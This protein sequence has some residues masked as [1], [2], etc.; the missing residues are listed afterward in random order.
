MYQSKD[1]DRDDKVTVLGL[2]WQGLKNNR[3]AA[4]NPKQPK[5][6]QQPNL[7]YG[8]QLFLVNKKSGGGILIFS[9]CLYSSGYSKHI[10]GVCPTVTYV[11]IKLNTLKIGLKEVYPLV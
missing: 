11:S 9:T 7:F 8:F 5:K 2:P 6:L 3:Y 10:V 1:Q 4:G